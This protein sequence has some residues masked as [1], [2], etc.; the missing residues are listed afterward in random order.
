MMK[1]FTCVKNFFYN[2]NLDY[3]TAKYQAFL[4]YPVYE[5]KKTK[6]FKRICYFFEGRGLA[7][8]GTQNL[9]YLTFLKAIIV[10]YIVMSLIHVPHSIIYY[11]YPPSTDQNIFYRFS[12]ANLNSN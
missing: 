5:N 11:W 4:E 3:K 6:K 7:E 12:I 9:L 2:P 8:T 1:M 10:L